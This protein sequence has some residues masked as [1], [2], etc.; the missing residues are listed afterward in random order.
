MIKDK[1]YRPEAMRL[2]SPDKNDSQLVRDQR[3]AASLY[4]SFVIMVVLSLLALTFAKIMSDRYIEIAESQLDLQAHYAAE[5]AINTVRSTIHKGLRDRDQVSDAA[6]DVTV[7]KAAPS[8]NNYGTPLSTGC[9]S[10]VAFGASLDV[11]GD[12]LAVGAPD[13]STGMV[14]LLTKKSDQWDWLDANITNTVSIGPLTGYEEPDGGSFGTAVALHTNGSIL[15]VGAPEDNSNRGSVYIFIK[16]SSGTWDFSIKI[17][18][19]PSNLREDN[20]DAN[21]LKKLSSLGASPRFGAALEWHEGNLLVGMPGESKVLR[22]DSS[23]WESEGNIGPGTSGFGSVI[24]SGS[25]RFE[26]KGKSANLAIGADNSEISLFEDGV[27]AKR[28]CEYTTGSTLDCLFKTSGGRGRG[29]SVTAFDI[30]GGVMAVGYGTDNSIDILEREGPAWSKKYRIM[31]PN[32]T[33]SGWQALKELPI[34]A[35]L[36]G[37]AL[38]LVQTQDNDRLLIVGDPGENKIHFFK[39]KSNDILNDI[40]ASGLDQDCPD[41]EDAHESWRNSQLSEVDGFEDIHYTCVSVEV[42]PA[43]LIYDHVGTDRSLVLPL[44]PAIGKNYE[45]CESGESDI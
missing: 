31:K 7:D 23:N 15:A 36:A 22:L 24:V 6:V 38:A 1:S 14:C 28:F 39:V 20:L 11:A 45:G 32:R 27:T 18:P 12:L 35:S 37:Q 17:I 21:K 16:N 43:S 5:S 26:E 13:T 10:A 29:Y 4:I 25:V 9:G 33:A 19:D 2:H 30:S 42:D 3:G 41:E 40:W 34:T 44:Y 8:G